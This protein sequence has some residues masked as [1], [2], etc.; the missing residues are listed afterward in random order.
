MPES[1]VKSNE[2]KQLN[3]QIPVKLVK[4]PVRIENVLNEMKITDLLSL[5]SYSE[6][7]LLSMHN[8]GKTSL[9][10]V[11]KI[12]TIM[13]LS[14]DQSVNSFIDSGSFEEYMYKR[15]LK[16]PLNYYFDSEFGERIFSLGIKNLDDIINYFQNKATRRG[17]TLSHWEESFL[18]NILNEFG[19]VVLEQ[20]S[21]NNI[22]DEENKR[23]E[24]FHSPLI[25]FIDKDLIPQKIELRTIDISKLDFGVRGNN[26]IKEMNIRN[27][28]EFVS[29]D[30]TVFLKTK[31]CGKKTIEIFKK[32]ILTYLNEI[33][34]LSNLEF[35]SIQ[36][37]VVYL[38]EKYAED[39][40]L[41]KVFVIKNRLE[42][43]KKRCLDEY[44]TLSELGKQMN[45]TRERVRQIE[46]KA[47]LMLFDSLD[48]KCQTFLT[49]LGEKIR[50]N[51]K[52]FLDNSLIK[53]RREILLIN[54]LFSVI[55]NKIKYIEHDSSWIY[56]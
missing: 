31:N 34:N 20:F 40:E 52:V 21:D 56:K 48:K 11:K 44:M 47:K 25:G 51:R 29:M 32:V 8:F 46:K 3:I 12:F 43:L 45:L 36:S 35:N 18:R 2:N 49:D 41:E 6:S 7:R 14:F 54:V 38:Q 53:Y 37:V 42:V 1:Q 23:E 22:I 16:F 13:D 17:L 4:I 5:T 9:E 39:K 27:L 15:K 26:I 10:Y 33:K 28:A 30:K 19:V 24:Y 55:D 50:N